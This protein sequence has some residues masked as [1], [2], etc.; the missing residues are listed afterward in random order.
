[1]RFQMTRTMSLSLVTAAVLLSAA[2]P[3]TARSAEPSMLD[4]NRS[5]AVRLLTE[6]AARRLLENL[7]DRP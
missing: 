2:F 3:P 7:G 4:W 5:A 1:M 6:M